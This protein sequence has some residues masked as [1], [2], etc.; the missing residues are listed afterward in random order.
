MLKRDVLNFIRSEL[1][2]AHPREAISIEAAV[3]ELATRLR[4]TPQAIHKWPET[5]D[6]YRQALVQ[7]ATDGAFKVEPDAPANYNSVARRGKRSRVRAAEAVRDR[8]G[9]ASD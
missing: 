4:M 2:D 9:L 8:L 5:L 7:V 6:F 1:Q 3:R